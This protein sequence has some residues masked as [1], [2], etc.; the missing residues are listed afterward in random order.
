MSVWSVAMVSEQLRIRARRTQVK[1]EPLEVCEA[2]VCPL[3]GGT[4]RLHDT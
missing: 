3:L 2:E 1:A 4:A